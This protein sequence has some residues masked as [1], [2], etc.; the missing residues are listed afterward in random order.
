[1]DDLDLFRTAK[2]FIDQYGADAPVQAAMRAD[3][4]M[5]RGDLQGVADW[6]RI[7]RAIGDLQNNAG[8]TRH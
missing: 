3:A 4:M 8:Q 6:K 5:E 1:M 2:L 7:V